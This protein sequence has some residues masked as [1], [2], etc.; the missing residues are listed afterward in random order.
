M[1]TIAVVRPDQWNLPLLLHVLGAMLLL[2][3]LSFAAYLLL[4][5]REGDVLSLKRF[6]YWTLL[7]GALPSFLL[8]RI[9]AQWVYDVEGFTGE[10][11]P[12]WIGI[13]YITGDLG[14]VPLLIALVLGGYGIRRVRTSEGT[15]Q[16]LTTAAGWLAVFLVAIYVIAV[17]AMT[18]KP[19]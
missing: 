17:W 10:D 18:A 14:A 15:K 2:G 4:A 3:T 1:T 12:T 5:P 19:G 13:G 11:D 7:A 16:G 9:A 6:G 8:M